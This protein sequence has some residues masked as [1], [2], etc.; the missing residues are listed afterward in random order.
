MK[1]KMTAKYFITALLMCSVMGCSIAQE[2]KEGGEESSSIGENEQSSSEEIAV[3]E[4]EDVINIFSSSGIDL[5]TFK[6]SR[7]EI[8]VAVDELTTL[9]S[10]ISIVENESEA[11]SYAEDFAELYLQTALM[12]DF[13]FIEYLQE[14]SQSD[15][16]L[17]VNFWANYQN[18]LIEAVADFANSVDSSKHKTAVSE[19]LGT[20]FIAFANSK[21]LSPLKSFAAVPEIFT[22]YYID[23]YPDA[24][25][26]FYSGVVGEEEEYSF[27]ETVTVNTLMEFLSLRREALS[28]EEYRNFLDHTLLQKGYSATQMETICLNISEYY[29]PLEEVIR[30]NL[31]VNL[32]MIYSAPQALYNQYASAVKTLSPVHENML[33]QM[34]EKGFIMPEADTISVN[35]AVNISGNRLPYISV[36]LDGGERN[37]ADM[38]Y[39]IGSAYCSFVLNDMPNP[40]NQ[41][42]SA[43][44]GK[45]HIFFMH[46]YYELIYPGAQKQAAQNDYYAII[47]NTLLNALIFELEEY[48]YTTE[49]LSEVGILQEFD[50]LYK[51]YFPA[52][53]SEGIKDAALALALNQMILQPIY[54]SDEIISS[55]IALEIGMV[56]E[57]EQS[58][59][60]RRVN[61]L[62]ATDSYA[63]LKTSLEKIAQPSPFS[64]VTFSTTAY[65]INSFS[66]SIEE[67]ENIE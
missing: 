16:S 20:D 41:W 52:E 62:L 15:I 35:S 24:Y 34:E 40:S 29:S 50:R 11:I 37:I 61:S 47:L 21:Q 67:A 12:R 6:Y 36:N 22:N 51:K 10:M 53:S 43:S 33:T 65:Y 49:K 3:M 2:T 30:E 5:N 27:D 48:A 59:G 7:P 42:L 60:M 58:E 54:S 1:Y 31:E 25:E 17:E 32:P 44:I 46:R 14:M 8:L 4:N 13:A 39:A 66:Q 26:V 63:P 57:R 9:A 38:S 18:E 56:S 55:V 23:V 64:S 19:A 28:E 45:S